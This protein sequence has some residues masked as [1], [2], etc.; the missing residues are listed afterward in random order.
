[1]ASPLGISGT[2]SRFPFSN[3]CST[4]VFK[5][6]NRLSSFRDTL[7]NLPSASSLFEGKHAWSGF[8][9]NNLVQ[10]IATFL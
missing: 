7:L 1:M 8:Q 9:S 5:S 3:C 4:T 10:Y 6:L 2:T